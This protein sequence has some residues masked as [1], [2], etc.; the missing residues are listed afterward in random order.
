[1]LQPADQRRRYWR[2]DERGFGIWTAASLVALAVLCALLWTSASGTYFVK[3]ITESHNIILVAENVRDWVTFLV[4]DVAA[5][6]DASAHPYWYIH[7]PNLF[8]KIISMLAG[9]ARLGLEGQVGIMLVLNVAALALLVA[10]FNRFSAAAALGAVVLAATSYGSFHF[11]AGDLCRGPLYLLLWL[12]LYASV[13][14]STLSDWRLNIATAAVSALAMLSDWGFGL[15]VVTFAFCWAAVG[16]AQVPWR[17]FFLWV[18]LPAA[19]AFVGYELAV[20]QA[21][22]FEFFLLDAKV[23]YLGRLGVGDFVDYQSLIS[24]FQEHNVVVWPAQGRGSDSLL[25]FVAA[26]VLMPLLNTGPAWLALLP[27]AV[28]AVAVTLSR[29]GLGRNAWLAIVAVVAL[30]II[31]LFPLP[32]LSI[33]ALVLALRLGRVPVSTPTERLTALVAC[34][35]LGLLGPGL[36]FPAFTNNFMIGGGRPPMPLLEMAS[37]ALLV[38]LAAA[39]ILKKFLAPAAPEHRFSVR[40]VAAAIAGT[41]LAAAIAVVRSDSHV[42][43]MPKEI[44]LGALV[45]IIGISLAGAVWLRVYAP[46]AP[47]PPFALRLIARWQITALLTATALS[48]ALHTSANP[49][50]LGRYSPAYFAVLALVAVAAVVALLLTI[51]PGLRAW[52]RASIE[53]SL[54][55]FAG[56]V[57]MPQTPG[58]R[59]AAAALVALASVQIGWLVVSIATQPPRPIP[60]AAVLEQPEFRGKSFLATTYEGVVWYSTRGWAYMPAANPPPA[61][62]IGVRFRHFADWRDD[63]KYDRPDYYLC[64]NTRFA[65]IPPGTSIED[66]P[67]ADM[68]CQKCTCR[69]VAATLASRGHQTVIDRDDFSIV[70]FRWPEKN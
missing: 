9:E 17:W 47:P 22:G 53:R 65:F 37:A 45:L 67:R 68:S 4:Q 52:L 36:V 10:A 58:D 40:M 27:L 33:V 21:V 19:V 15:F 60:Y 29:L 8:A 64:D 32:L 54:R 69:D 11:N 18:L 25:Q 30:N 49:S 44:V 3:S 42:F 24:L 38:Q 46:A 5:S 12:L 31:G 59:F 35:V 13:A 28:G 16:R 7:H 48:L 62:P 34:A 70:R 51:A 14:N 63:A 57:S 26:V 39:G 41:L 23:T 20:I 61:G 2:S 50:I 56:R 1:M 43:G 6:P 66:A 55:G